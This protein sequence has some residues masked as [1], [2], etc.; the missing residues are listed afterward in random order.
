MLVSCPRRAFGLHMIIKAVK[1]TTGERSAAGRRVSFI[2]CDPFFRKSRAGRIRVRPAG[3]RA[4][5][6]NTAGRHRSFGNGRRRNEPS[7]RRR[8]ACRRAMRHPEIFYCCGSLFSAW[9]FSSDDEMIERRASSGPRPGSG[10]R[11]RK[12]LPRR[13]LCGPGNARRRTTRRC[14]RGMGFPECPS[15]ARDGAPGLHIIIK[16]AE[17]EGEE[18]ARMCFVS[19]LMARIYNRKKYPRQEKS[20]KN[21]RGSG[22][23]ARSR[24]SHHL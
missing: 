20:M 23:P 10:F 19:R 5:S 18:E 13:C 12:L 9:P 21:E 14:A 22:R 6:T 8:R 4:R 15:L 11:S 3:R 2:G 1:R 7:A 16:G 17:N 24:P